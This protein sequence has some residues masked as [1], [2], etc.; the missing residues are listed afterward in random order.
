MS[1]PRPGFLN[2]AVC[3]RTSI[4]FWLLSNIDRMPIAAQQ[5]PDPA[6]ATARIS[7]HRPGNPSSATPT[8]VHAG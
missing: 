1:S 3:E 6:T 8:A 7:R 4:Y 5:A 2:T